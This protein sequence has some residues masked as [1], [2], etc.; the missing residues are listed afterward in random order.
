M[1][2]ILFNVIFLL[3]CS[4]PLPCIFISQLRSLT[5]VV[6]DLVLALV[7][8][9]TA[10]GAAMNACSSP[11]V[12]WRGVKAPLELGNLGYVSTC[13]RKKRKIST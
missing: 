3:A 4:S 10:L 11:E 9:L 13:Q 5:N 6:P 2:W 8:S 12:T 1:S 7:K